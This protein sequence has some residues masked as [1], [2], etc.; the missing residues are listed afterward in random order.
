MKWM[1]IE[2]GWANSTIE[3]KWWSLWRQLLQNVQIF[4]PHRINTEKKCWLQLLSFNDN[5]NDN[6]NDDDDD[7]DDQN[8]EQ[9]DDDDDENTIKI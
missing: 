2:C 6:D 3:K 9:G 5:D 8:D 7:E 1:K 4:F